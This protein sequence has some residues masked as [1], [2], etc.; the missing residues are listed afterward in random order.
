MNTCRIKGTAVGSGN[1]LH[2]FCLVAERSGKSEVRNESTESLQVRLSNVS[3]RLSSIL[4][5]DGIDVDK[6]VQYTALLLDGID[7]GCQCEV[8]AHNTVVCWSGIILDFLYEHNIWSVQ[9]LRNVFGDSR[10]V[11]GIRC[12]VL[13]LAGIN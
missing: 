7:K 2:F 3:T 5:I 10:N 6:T 8:G 13:H 4:L 12:H 9:V 1:Q 11:T